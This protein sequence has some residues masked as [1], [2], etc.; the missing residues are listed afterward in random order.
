ME[1]ASGNGKLSKIIKNRV[2]RA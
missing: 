2:S 1:A